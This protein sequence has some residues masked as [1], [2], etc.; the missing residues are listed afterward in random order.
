MTTLVT[1]PD[2]E[3]LRRV[4][5]VLGCRPMDISR[6]SP[7]EAVAFVAERTAYLEER[8][9]QRPDGAEIARAQAV[10]SDAPFTHSA[11]GN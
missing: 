1:V 11:E 7:A 8:L 4:E 3:R 2:V 6:L 10:D 5:A 9:H